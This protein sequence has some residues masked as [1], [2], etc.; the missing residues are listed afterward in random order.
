MTRIMVMSRMTLTMWQ[1]ILILELNYNSDY[2]DDMS[3]DLNEE[4]DD[5][6]ADNLDQQDSVASEMTF[7]E[8]LLHSLRELQ[9]RKN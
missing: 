8:D 3:E 4:L 5:L 7:L 6:L 1:M 9:K 2:S